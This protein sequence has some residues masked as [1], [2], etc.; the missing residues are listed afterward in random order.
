MLA[1]NRPPKVFSL[2]YLLT[3][4]INHDLLT[5]RTPFSVRRVADVSLTRERADGT[6][7]A[8]F[9]FAL[10]TEA[11]QMRPYHAKQLICKTSLASEVARFG[12]DK[13]IA[14]DG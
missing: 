2:N 5:C 13:E 9:P 14:L 4:F 10:T 11:A 7:Y 3:K 12:L 8:Y 6:Y 1:Q